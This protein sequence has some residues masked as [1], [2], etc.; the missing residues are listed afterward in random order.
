MT[1]ITAKKWIGHLTAIISHFKVKDSNIWN[2]DESPMMIDHP[3]PVLVAHVP[4]TTPMP[5]S[6]APR[7]KNS[8]LIVCVAADGAHTRSV[9]LW[10]LESVPPEFSQLPLFGIDPVCHGKGW[11]DDAEYEELMMNKILPQIE[12]RRKETDSEGWSLLLMDVHASRRNVPTIQCAVEKRIQIVILPP[13]STQYT[14]P[15]DQYV[16]AQLKK[17]LR[18]NFT[19]PSPPNEANY[20]RMFS[21]ALADAVQEGLKRRTIS[22]S[23]RD[24]GIVPLSVDPIVDTLPDQL[25]G[26]SGLISQYF[27]DLSLCL[28][29]SF[30][31]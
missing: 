19:I 12:E 23:F 31:I 16:F 20:R 4:G 25:K 6:I 13:N 9:L 5:I 3:T 15:L 30:Y 8:T 29:P 18:S 26:E 10:P 21:L 17:T 7:H 14:Q 11:I 28:S 24:C 1:E 2:L 27:L 22:A